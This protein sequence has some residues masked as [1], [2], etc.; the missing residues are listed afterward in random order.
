MTTVVDW[1][2]C[3]NSTRT[4]TPLA[5]KVTSSDPLITLANTTICQTNESSVKLTVFPA[6]YSC[7][8]KHHNIGSFSTMVNSFSKTMSE[9]T[10]KICLF[11]LFFGV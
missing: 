6:F 2:D 9:I 1:S 3:S 10:L 4:V 7:S 5:V 11:V 8:L